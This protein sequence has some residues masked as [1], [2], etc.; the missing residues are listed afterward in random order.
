MQATLVGEVLQLGCFDIDDV[1]GYVQLGGD[2]RRIAHDAVAPVAGTYAGQQGFPRLPQR[3]YRA[4][5]PVFQHLLIDPIRGAAQGQF[6]QGD[7]VSLAEEILDRAFGLVREVDLAFLEALQQFI[8]WQV[9]QHHFIGG[10]EYMVGHGLPD[11][12]SGNAADH[13]IKG[14]QVLDVDRR[15]D[16]DAGRQQFVHVLPALGMARALDV[17][18]GQF[19]H[20]DEFRRACQGTIDVELLQHLVAVRHVLQRQALQSIHQG[21]GFLPAVGFHH[22]DD[23]VG[24]LLRPLA[25][26][27]QHGVGLADAGRRAEKYLQLAARGTNLLILDLVEELVGIGASVGHV[28]VW[29]SSAKFSSN[30]LTRASPKRPKSRPCVCASIRLAT[31][32]MDNLRAAAMR[33]NW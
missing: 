13:I 22:A 1:P 32:S 28:P 4:V 15:I 8:G 5:A 21:L 10:V 11:A 24:T 25:R 20:Q 18:M 2:A 23:H 12:D 9:D 14:F 16:V 29:L 27:G 33:C 7:Q 19:V 26:G 31:R 17:G 3:R 30:T 6:A